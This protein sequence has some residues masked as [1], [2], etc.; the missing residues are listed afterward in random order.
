MN[1]AREA[2]SRA[3][4]R[5]IADGSPV[6][7]NQPLNNET[8][9][10]LIEHAIGHLDA[11]DTDAIAIL[12]EAYKAIGPL[13]QIPSWELYTVYYSNFGY[14]SQERFA[15]VEDAIEYGK[16]KGFEFSV[17]CDRQ[18]LIYAWGPIKS[19]HWYD[20]SFRTVSA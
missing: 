11:S 4:N 7:V 14:Y 17:G 19:G 15:T 6:Y 9:F 20:E 18:P 13:G 3:V 1:A 2:L 5:A 8:A 16:S 10:M 12:T